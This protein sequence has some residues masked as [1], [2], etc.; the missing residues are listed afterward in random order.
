MSVC[1]L[2]EQHSTC[3]WS[4]CHRLLPGSASHSVVFIQK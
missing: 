2:S 1:R 3:R 4:D